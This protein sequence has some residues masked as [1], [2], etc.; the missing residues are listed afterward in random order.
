M[1]KI[2]RRADGWQRLVA[3]YSLFVLKR[4]LR[5]SSLRRCSDN[6][7]LRSSTAARTR[8]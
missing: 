7:E 1:L 6:R 8:S 5:A 2:R 4:A 3:P